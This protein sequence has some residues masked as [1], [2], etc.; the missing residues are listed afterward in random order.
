LLDALA[1]GELVVLHRPAARASNAAAAAGV[2][3]SSDWVIF[4][5]RSS[6][7]RKRRLTVKGSS[8]GVA[9]NGTL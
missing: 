4:V 8:A 3:S 1:G 7:A 5:S 6:T 9:W 2:C